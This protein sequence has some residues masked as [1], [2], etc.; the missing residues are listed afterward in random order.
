MGECIAGEIIH[1]AS[2]Q[3]S[4]GSICIDPCVEGNRGNR[5]EG[6]SILLF[7]SRLLPSS[8]V[9]QVRRS[10]LLSKT[11]ATRDLFPSRSLCR[12]FRISHYFVP[13]GTE[14]SEEQRRRLYYSSR[15]PFKPSIRRKLRKFTHYYQLPR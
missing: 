6:S 1:I 13:G 15:A 3:R 4:K 9:S 8:I 14:R 5:A 2:F 11:S 12:S 7:L 10:T